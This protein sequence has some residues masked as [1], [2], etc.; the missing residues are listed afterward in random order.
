M[1]EPTSHLDA[2]NEEKVQQALSGL[3]QGKT[4]LMIAHRLR[5]IANA[6]QILVLEEGRLTGMGSHEELLKENELY[7][8]LWELQEEEL[9]WE[10][11]N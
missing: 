4:V 2:E 11:E 9:T 5:N 1:D 8:H 10:L 3:L 7:R 6:D